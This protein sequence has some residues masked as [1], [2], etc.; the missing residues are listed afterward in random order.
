MSHCIDTNVVLKWFLQDEPLSQ[1]ASR[2]LKD[3]KESSDQYVISE[4]VL[5]EFVWGLI[6]SGKSAQKVNDAYEFLLSLVRLDGLTMVPVS[7]VLMDLKDLQVNYNMYGSDA[8][9]LATALDMGCE[10]F[11]TED[12]HFRKRKLVGDM[13]ERGLMIASVEK[14]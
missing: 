4:W 2:I 12:K 1:D 5:P 8:V 3:I 10:V 7:D 6:K 9:H 14:Y 11:W 13:R